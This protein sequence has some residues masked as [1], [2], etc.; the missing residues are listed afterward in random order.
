LNDP[1]STTFTDP[2]VAS[3]GINEQLAIDKYGESDV[4]ISFR[5][6][7]KIDRA[8][9]EGVSAHGFIKIVYNTRTKHVLGASIVAPSAGELISEIAVAMDSKL[10]FDKLATVMHSYPSYSIAL[11]Q[12]A[13][14]V[15]YDKLKKNRVYY[16]LLKK[17]GL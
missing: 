10:P 16:D 7:T 11:Q 3:V 17:L 8:I 6:L 2:E 4:S 15:Y 14:Q 5:P 13:A 1:P 9:C 12:M